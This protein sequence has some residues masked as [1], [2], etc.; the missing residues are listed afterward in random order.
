MVSGGALNLDPEPLL[1][2][3]LPL[4]CLIP[5]Q[6]WRTPGIYSSSMCMLEEACVL[7]R[8]SSLSKTGDTAYPVTPRS[9][10]L[11]EDR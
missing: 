3:S 11:E 1:F 7:G 10:L 9:A 4:A 6:G 2:P 8:S 5:Q